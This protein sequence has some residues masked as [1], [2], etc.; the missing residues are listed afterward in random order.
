MS[1][2]SKPSS[3]D[4][5][6]AEEG[7]SSSERPKS[8]KSRDSVSFVSEGLEAAAACGAAADTDG[9]VSSK[10]PISKSSSDISVSIVSLV[11]EES[12][13]SEISCAGRS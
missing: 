2:V 3:R 7:L 9:S 12:G 10:L 13:F 6:V 1:I 5:A 4:S 8:D 11:G